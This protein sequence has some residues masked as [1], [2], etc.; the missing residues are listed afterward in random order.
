MWKQSIGKLSV[1][2]VY[3][4][5]GEE[6]EQAFPKIVGSRTVTFSLE[7]VRAQNQ[8]ERERDIEPNSFLS[9]P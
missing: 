9:Y 7:T 4:P 3:H 1:P 2:G 6:K 5:G 8:T